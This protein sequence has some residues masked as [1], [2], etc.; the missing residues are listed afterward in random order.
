MLCEIGFKVFVQR[1]R[2]A[3]HL[4]YFVAVPDGDADTGRQFSRIRL[5]PLSL[6]STTE[7]LQPFVI[8]TY[9]YFV[10]GMQIQSQRYISSEWCY[11]F[12]DISS[13]LTGPHGHILIGGERS[14]DR[15]RRSLTHTGMSFITMCASSVKRYDSG[16]SH[17]TSR[18]GRHMSCTVHL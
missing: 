6:Q 14:L 12:C 8:L 2:I 11:H 3:R 13:F 18:L 15:A 4:P 10:L 7:S 9:I 17:R 16:R 1:H 5:L